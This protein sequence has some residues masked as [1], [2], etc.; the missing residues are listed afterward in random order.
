MFRYLNSF[1]VGRVYLMA[2]IKRVVCLA[3][4][5][6]FAVS[7]ARADLVGYWK[8][9]DDDATDSSAYGNN[10]TLVNTPAFTNDVP[11]TIS[12]GRS[13]SFNGSDGDGSYVQVPHSSSLSFTGGTVTVSFW[14]K[15]NADDTSSW[16]RVLSNDNG[17]SHGFEIQRFENSTVASLR[18]DT[19]TENQTI[20]VGAIWNGD[21]NHVVFSLDN[22]K[23]NVWLNGSH[24]INNASYN[25]TGGFDNTADF[26]M[27]RT[28]QED[29]REYEGLLDDVAVWN[30]A[31][32]N[33][34]ALA[35]Y[36]PILGYDVTQMQTLFNVYT[37][38]VPATID[39]LQWHPVSNLQMGE[40][41]SFAWPNRNEFYLQ[42]DAAGNGVAATN[43]AVDAIELVGYWTF[44]GDDA[45]DSSYFGNDGTVEPHVVFTNDTATGTGQSVA[46]F[47]GSDLLARINVPPSQSLAVDDTM[48]LCFWMK[49]DSAM[50]VWTRLIR[51]GDESNIHN[52]WIVNRYES[53]SNLA[54]R[55][56]TQAGGG[57]YNQNQLYSSGSEIDGTWHHVVIVADN[58]TTKK[59]V[60][61]VSVGTESY[62]HGT[63][64]GNTFPLE[65]NNEGNLIG[66]LD[67]ISLWYNAL[68]DGM[69]KSLYDPILG[70]DQ[71]KMQSLFNIFLTGESQM[72]D[73]R[74]WSKVSGL[75][76]GEGQSAIHGENYLLQLDDAGNGVASF[77]A[78]ALILVQ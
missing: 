15:A 44:D 41:Q 38:G 1:F 24:T 9:E 28:F 48:T 59:F 23:I 57:T 14:M 21:W 69:A 78:G 11:A 29:N 30:T 74:L 47:G 16:L 42:F 31:L 73:G 56:D 61:G 18:I 65:I 70:F 3:L 68:T 60:D 75:T 5:A 35:L 62:D 55:Y 2:G 33:G 17:P 46:F 51:K 71:T 49:M 77:I 6:V 43:L 53:S 39:G 22:G 50:P 58:G 45:S 32:S 13:I 40:G 64:F 19:D 76:L 63:G 36:K 37:S 66:C 67:E 10:G 52:N 27:G 26:V 8:F 7:Q 25:Q 34:M 54:I 12:S 20:D 4:L 72:I